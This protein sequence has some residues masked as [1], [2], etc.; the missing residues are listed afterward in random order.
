MVGKSGHGEIDNIRT[1]YGM[2][3]PRMRDETIARIEQRI[4]AWSNT[5]VVQQED[6]QARPYLH[7]LYLPYDMWTISVN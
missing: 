3:L 4:A 2:F 1:S 7:G 5:T 6:M